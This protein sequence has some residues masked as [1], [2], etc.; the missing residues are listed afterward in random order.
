MYNS[1]FSRDYM[2]RI[3]GNIT[4]C[5][6]YNAMYNSYEIVLVD[7]SKYSGRNSNWTRIF[8]GTYSQCKWYLNNKL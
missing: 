8:S 7:S 4:H 2:K 1:T 6:Y 3:N 5:V